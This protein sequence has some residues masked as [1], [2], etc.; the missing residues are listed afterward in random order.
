[1]RSG[2]VGV[3]QNMTSS[4]SN[5]LQ[6]RVKEIFTD[7][8]TYGKCKHYALYLQYCIYRVSYNLDND[9]PE[10]NDCKILLHLVLRDK[11][12]TET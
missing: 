4:L 7:K 6:T 5:L 1:M 8:R 10:D 11:K 2:W 12:R 9:E 3:L